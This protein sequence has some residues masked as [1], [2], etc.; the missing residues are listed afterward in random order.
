MQK[1]QKKMMNYFRD[2]ALQT[3]EQIVQIQLIG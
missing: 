3:D 1:N 2:F